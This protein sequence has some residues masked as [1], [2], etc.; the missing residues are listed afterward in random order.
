M[1]CRSAFRVWTCDL[2]IYFPLISQI[3]ADKI[4]VDLQLPVRFE[5]IICEIGAFSGQILHFNSVIF[6]YSTI[7]AQWEEFNSINKTFTFHLAGPNFA[8]AV[9]PVSIT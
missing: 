2:S 1:T 3:Y 5:R 9:F 7:A 6:E 4:P 8:L